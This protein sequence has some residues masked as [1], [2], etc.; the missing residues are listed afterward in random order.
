MICE[1]LGLCD[2][3]EIRMRAWLARELRG[4]RGVRY[5]KIELRWLGTCGVRDVPEV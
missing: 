2:K 1:K 4:A 5:V 3:C